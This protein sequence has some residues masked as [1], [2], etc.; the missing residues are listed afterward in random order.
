MTQDYLAGPCMEPQRS[1]EEGNSEGHK[2]SR[3]NTT[4]ETGCQAAAL[5]MVMASSEV[6]KERK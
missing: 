2:K 1:P 3:G 4:V 6:G 5:Q